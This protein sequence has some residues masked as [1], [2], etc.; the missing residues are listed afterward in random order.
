MRVLTGRVIGGKVEVGSDLPD[1]T[2]VA[3]FAPQDEPVVLT[4]AEQAE[5]ADALDEIHRGE[6]EDAFALLREIKAQAGR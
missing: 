5:L 1:G 3:V 4:P 2:R 6:S